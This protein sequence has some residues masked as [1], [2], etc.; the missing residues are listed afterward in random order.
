MSILLVEL[1][2]KQIRPD[3]L[4]FT[5]E[6]ETLRTLFAF[7]IFKFGT[8]LVAKPF[9][10]LLTFVLLIQLEPNKA[11]QTF[12]V[13]RIVSFAQIANFLTVLLTGVVP[14]RTLQAYS[15]F[16]SFAVRVRYGEILIL[17][18]IFVLQFEAN[19]AGKART[20]VFVAFSTLWVKDFAPARL[21]EVGSLRTLSTESVDPFGAV[22]VVENGFIFYTIP[23]L[24][25]ETD[26][27]GRTLAVRL[28]V[29]FALGI[30]SFTSAFVVL[31]VPVRTL[32]AVISIKLLTIRVNL[33]LGFLF[34][35]SVVEFVAS[36][37]TCALPICFVVGFAEGIHQLTRLITC[38]KA[39]GSTFSTFPVFKPFT[40]N[41][42]H[43]LFR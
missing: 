21:M 30:N 17:N 36:K 40:V 42:S 29:S 41:L 10:I 34:A 31:E 14:L 18:T 27:A 22:G 12:A 25:F 15:I 26:E 1:L 32:L 11:T 5:V 2:T 37:A 9:F 16:E 23:D 43:L 3:T 4:P 6:V 24:N 38:Q 35:L 33:F 28:F 39:L 20:I 13:I 19:I 7:F 8:V